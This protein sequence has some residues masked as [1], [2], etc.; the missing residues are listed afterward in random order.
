MKSWSEVEKQEAR[1]QQILDCMWVYTYKFNRDGTLK[2]CKAR[3]VVRGDQQKPSSQETYAATLAARSFRIMMAIAA[4]FDL[5]LKQYDA[6][7]AFVNAPLKDTV[8]MRKPPGYKGPSK[9]L[10][11]RKALYGLRQSPLLWQK[12]L[13]STLRALGFHTIPHE[14]CILIKDGILIFFYVDDIVLAYRKEDTATA[15]QLV[16]SLQQ[17]YQFTGGN[18]LQWFLGIEVIRDRS[19][20]LIWLS[21]T[22]YLDKIVNLA[23]TNPTAKV[24]MSAVKLLPYDGKA[25]PWSITAY[26]Q[27][28]G[29]IL[30]AAVITRPDIAF[31]A[32]QLVR[33][34][35]NPSPQHHKA[36]DQVLYYLHNTRTLALQLGG[37]DDYVV[38]SDASFADNSLDRKSSQ[39]YAMKLFG[40]L[41][42][43][44]ANK[45]DTV[46]TSTT[47]AELLALAQAAKES[48]FV[49]RL[50]TELTIQL[51]D[52]HIKI[53]C[54]NKQTIRLVTAEMAT[55]QTRLRH[56]DIHNHWLRQEVAN[57]KIMVEYTPS[58]AIVADGLTK[59]LNHTL[60]QAFIKQLGLAEPPI[61]KNDRPSLELNSLPHL[62]QSNV[63]ITMPEKVSVL[64]KRV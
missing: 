5:E 41:V 56:V 3:I 1:G 48:L 15:Q 33:F 21:Q 26:Q 30:Y 27:K 52:Q 25:E 10:R 40:G 8:Y 13:T 32:S 37:A 55:L 36:A 59:A 14:P 9:V 16:R 43:W 12:E 17:K 7:N 51:D 45:Q 28:T 42:G 60:H 38:A 46:T 58:A 11:L 29:S 63:K 6:I 64:V 54:D 61:E 50:L 35:N 44:R 4:R 20:R 19:Q 62:R 53:Q 2:N 22:A 34:N 47:E 39:A 18:D 24:P 49:S 57:K 23:T 31:A